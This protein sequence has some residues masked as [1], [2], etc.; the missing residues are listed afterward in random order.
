MAIKKNG[1]LSGLIGNIVNYSSLGKEIVRIHVADPKQSKATKASAKDFGKIKKISRFLRMALGNV[2]KDNKGKPAMFAMDEAVRRWYYQFYLK[3][4]TALMDPVYFSSLQLRPEAPPSAKIILG[5]D[6]VIDWNVEGKVVLHIPAMKRTDLMLPQYANR[7]S[8]TLVV[9]GIR[10]P[11]EKFSRFE[12]T[13]QA[14]SETI[15]RSVRVD[16]IEAVTIELEGLEPLDNALF[17]AF[18]SL[19]YERHS[20]WME[21][22]KWKPVVVVGSKFRDG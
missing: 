17:L 13:C 5:V 18:L 7:I 22:E 2:M 21:E 12:D 8:F 9:S 1:G 20:E 16:D 15:E 3:R 14:T 11:G 10:P 19:R 4:E 6:P